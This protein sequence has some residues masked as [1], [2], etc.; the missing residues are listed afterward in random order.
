LVGL[1]KK[2]ASLTTQT[3]E[4]V[5]IHESGHAMMALLYNDDFVFKKASIQPTYNGAGGYTLYT[6]KPEIREGGLYTKDLLMKRLI[7]MMGGKAAESVFYG[8]DHCSLGAIEDLRQANN[9]A[10]RMIGNFGFGNTLEVFFN[11][12]ISDESN[13]FLGRSLSMG[14]KYSENTKVMMDKESLELVKNAYLDAKTIL[15]ENK[16][17]MEIIIQKLLKNEVLTGK[18]MVEFIS[19]KQ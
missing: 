14:D 4:R 15:I 19:K 16:E 8:N 9:L 7:V 1:I 11:E 3:I 2:N 10:R 18:E 6:E 17:S 13:P 12:D 5:A